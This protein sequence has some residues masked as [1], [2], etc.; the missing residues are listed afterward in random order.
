MPVEWWQEEDRTYLV[1]D[2]ISANGQD[3]LPAMALFVVAGGSNSLMLARTIEPMAGGG[4]LNVI[5]LFR[6]MEDL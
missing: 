3:G 4:H 5:D 2:L 6:E 1:F